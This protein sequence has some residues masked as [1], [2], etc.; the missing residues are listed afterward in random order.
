[1]F[2]MNTRSKNKE[3]IPLN[4]EIKRT[5]KRERRE[6]DTANNQDQV[7]VLRQQLDEIQRK[8]AEQKMIT[9]EPSPLS[10]NQKYQ[11]SM[12]QFQEDE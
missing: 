5:Y 12:G 3:I 11:P 10:L 1:M 2:H 6:R 9:K 4:F 8:F 7:V